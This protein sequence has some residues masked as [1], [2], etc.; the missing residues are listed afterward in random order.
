MPRTQT[1][2]TNREKRHV[3]TQVARIHAERLT[4][5]FEGSLS[6]TGPGRSRPTAQRTKQ[7]FGC[8]RLGVPRHGRCHTQVSRSNCMV[9]D[10]RM[11]SH[12]APILAMRF[13]KWRISNKHSPAKPGHSCLCQFGSLAHPGGQLSERVS[14]SISATAG[15]RLK[16]VAAD[17]GWAPRGVRHPAPTACRAHRH[18]AM[19]VLHR[20]TGAA[21]VR[22]PWTRQLSPA[23]DRAAS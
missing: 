16:E 2:I 4:D 15:F 14:G 5:C 17:F 12:A 13:M 6:V 9:A 10:T 23:R 3:K 18:A 19:S 20:T 11:M 22:R 7:P 1:V 21:C 8:S